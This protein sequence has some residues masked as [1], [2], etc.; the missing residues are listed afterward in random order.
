MK[1][2]ILILMI[3]ICLGTF[4]CSSLGGLLA[5]ETTDPRENSMAAISSPH[6]GFLQDDPQSFEVYNSAPYALH[7][8]FEDIASHSN[9]TPIHGDGGASLN[10]YAACLTLKV[11]F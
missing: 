7:I 10:A 6:A 5:L 8:E 3:T 2:R 9:Q 1:I 11:M 4:G